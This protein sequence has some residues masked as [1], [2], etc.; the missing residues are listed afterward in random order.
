MTAAACLRDLTI[1]LSTFGGDLPIVEEINLTLQRG[2]IFGLVGES[3]GGKSVLSSAFSGLIAKPLNIA[4]GA[5]EVDGRPVVPGDL[6]GLREIRGRKVGMIFQDPMTSLNPVFTVGDQ[7]TETVRHLCA[8][9]VQEAAERA[10]TL[11]EEVGIARPRERMKAL[12]QELSGG[13]RQRVVIALALAGDPTLLIADEPTTALDVSVQAQVMELIRKLAAD[14]EMSVLFITHDIALVGSIANRIGV[15]YAG[16]LVEVGAISEVL[17]RPKHPYT[18]GLLASIPTIGGPLGSLHHVPG[19]VPP[20]DAR[21]S[22]CSFTPR[23]DR[24]LDCCLTSPPPARVE[25]CGRRVLCWNPLA[26]GA[27]A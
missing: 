7:L 3:G 22:M 21:S 10:V 9:T 1:S 5:I 18:A 15:L 26:E 20:L 2:E 8:C 23:C 16:R 12:P 27:H 25:G 11:L 4:S 14:R 24:A 13:M 6:T 19:R 17:L